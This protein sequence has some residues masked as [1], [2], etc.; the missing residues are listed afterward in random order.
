MRTI[1]I[2]KADLDENNYYKQDGIACVGP[3]FYRNIEIDEDL[4]LVKF[5]EGVYVT[6][7]IIAK[8]GSGIKADLGIKAGTGI[9]A[10][11]GIKA[12]W[13]IEAGTGI[14]AGAG[15]EAGLGIDAGSGIKAGAGIKAGTGIKAGWG[16]EAG[17]GITSLYSWVKAKQI[18][19][20]NPNCT[21]SAGIFSRAGKREI[22]AQ[23][24][25]GGEVIYGEVTLR[26][27]E[28]KKSDDKTEE[29][30]SILKEK[31]YRIIK[32]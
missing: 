14:E 25:K 31:G 5:R 2:T 11:L 15:I 22:E 30:I 4:G 7:S 10:D 12:G 21:L 32:E 17:S 29:A 20:F 26:P 1:K 8:A 19:S 28:N 9:K 24:I 6:G 3:G 23:E 16:I 18:I 13:G 27:K